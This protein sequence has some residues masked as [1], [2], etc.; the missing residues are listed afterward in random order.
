M[1]KEDADKAQVD[2]HDDLEAIDGIGPRYAKALT[3]VGVRRFAD[4]V[5]HTPRSLAE[6]LSKQAGLRVSEKQIDE[7]NWIGQARLALAQKDLPF[8]V[9]QESPAEPASAEVSADLKPEE[10]WEQMFEF[11]VFFEARTEEAGKQHWQTRVYNGRSGEEEVLS[12][13]EPTGWANWILAHTQLPEVVQTITVQDD[14]SAMRQR[15]QE[16]EEAY[17]ALDAQVQATQAEIAALRQTLQDRD[18]ELALLREK[19]STV[20]PDEA[21]DV[22][23]SPEEVTLRSELEQARA[24]VERYKA[25]YNR[26]QME[27]EKAIGMFASQRRASIGGGSTAEASRPS[28]PAQP[29][30]METAAFSSGQGTTAQ[31]ESIGG[32]ATVHHPPQKLALQVRRVDLP[33]GRDSRPGDSVTGEVHFHLGGVEATRLSQM[34][35]PYRVE[36]RG[37]SPTSSASSLLAKLEGQ[38]TPNVHDYALPF[39]CALPAPGTYQV[40][41]TLRLDTGTSTMT[42]IFQGRT[43]HINVQPQ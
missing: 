6:I 5:K 35:M 28:S 19:V 18:Q 15:L 3:Q 2:A 36:L 42:T 9:M 20:Q 8:P 41:A 24:E 22:V 21:T 7:R 33:V 10:Q 1:P 23:E 31:R 40:Y 37:V 29:V 25:M 32:K 38:L 4:L 30:R 14:V 11:S 27:V 17:K 16:A 13:V 43:F 39:S 26:A 34:A 12:S